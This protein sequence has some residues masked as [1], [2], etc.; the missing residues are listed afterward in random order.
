MGMNRQQRKAAEKK[1]KKTPVTTSAHYP[2]AELERLNS[3]VDKA[4]VLIERQQFLA[5]SE[6]LLQVIKIKPDHLD[7][8]SN[9]AMVAKNLENYDAAINLFE[10]IKK[11]YPNILEINIYLASIYSHMGDRDKFFEILEPYKI[12]LARNAFYHHSVGLTYSYFGEKEPCKASF[13][14]ACELEPDN[15]QYLYS[16]FVTADHTPEEKD[17]FSLDLIKRLESRV[18]DIVNRKDKIYAYYTLFNVYHKW[19][20]YD[21]AFDFLTKGSQLQRQSSGYIHE[22]SMARIRKIPQY[23][24]EDFYKENVIQHS[25]TTT[26]APTPVFIMGMPR[27]GTTLLEQILCAHPEITGIGEDPFLD[28]RIPSSLSFPERNGLACPI[29]KL[30]DQKSKLTAEKLGT[31]YIEHIKKR[32]GGQKFIINKSIGTLH[33]AGALPLIIPSCKII[34]IR[35]NPMDACLSMYTKL[36]VGGG[37]QYTYNLEELGECYQNSMN[38]AEHWE[39]VLSNYVHTVEYEK[40]VNNPSEE[41]GKILDFLGTDWDDNCLNFYKSKQHV[42][43]ASSNQ[44]REQINT[45]SI[46]RWRSYAKHLDPLINNLGEYAPNDA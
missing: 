3:I 27:S 31:L 16:Y 36:F 26:N 34:H 45:K 11:I 28:K 4:I 40:L 32:S 18:D 14:K 38:V 6:L 39:H 12:K 23:F 1:A 43:T 21:K 20:A 44:V 37:I 9:M 10:S 46:Q 19:G 29:S 35:R 25:D 7:A 8:L 5:A 22:D 30:K 24:T 15:Y 41:I 2:K 42:R 17:T 33:I 13:K